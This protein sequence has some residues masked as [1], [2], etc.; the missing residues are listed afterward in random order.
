MPAMSY[1][2]YQHDKMV[3]LNLANSTIITNTVTP[4]A[5]QLMP[6]RLA[7]TAGVIVGCNA[8]GKVA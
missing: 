1:R 5:L 3:V 6:Q 8:F 7:E 4:Q 2:Q